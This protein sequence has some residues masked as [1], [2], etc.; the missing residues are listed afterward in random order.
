MGLKGTGT[1]HSGEM[2]WSVAVG[3]VEGT[4]AVVHTTLLDLR[5]ERFAAAAVSIGRDAER[6]HVHDHNQTGVDKTVLLPVRRLAAAVVVAVVGGDV[7]IA[8]GSVGQA[9]E[10]SGGLIVTKSCQFVV[11]VVVVAVV[12]MCVFADSYDLASLEDAG[13]GWEFVDA[14]RVDHLEQ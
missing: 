6:N 4:C 13:P 9:D 1:S 11:V 7:W 8:V 12:M 3:K 5:R 10:Q 2:C 14:F